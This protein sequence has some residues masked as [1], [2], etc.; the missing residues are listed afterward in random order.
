MQRFQPELGALKQ[1][2]ILDLRDNSIPTSQISWL[3]QQ[4]PHCKI[5]VKKDPS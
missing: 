3:Q 4:L 1:L 5:V 2:Q